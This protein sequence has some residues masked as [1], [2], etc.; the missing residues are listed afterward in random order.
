MNCACKSGIDK[1]GR[2][3]TELCAAHQAE[4]DERHEA[5]VKSCSHVYRDMQIEQDGRDLS[6]AGRGHLVGP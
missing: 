2:E 6:D 5:S 4:H 1:H 3:W